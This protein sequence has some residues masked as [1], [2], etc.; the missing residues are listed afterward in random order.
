MTCPYCGS[1]DCESENREQTVWYCYKCKRFF[2][3]ED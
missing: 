1:E 2:K 3:S